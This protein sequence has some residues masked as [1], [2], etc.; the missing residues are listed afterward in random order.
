[1]SSASP[2]L[3]SE[4]SFKP[5]DFVAKPPLEDLFGL[6]GIQGG[7]S[8][9]FLIERNMVTRRSTRFQQADGTSAADQEACPQKMPTQSRTAQ[10]AFM[11][12]PLRCSSRLEGD[13]RLVSFLDRR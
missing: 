7:D 13:M 11:A 6:G 2:A 9:A 5:V 3:N 4:F 12:S 1:M 8:S 10:S